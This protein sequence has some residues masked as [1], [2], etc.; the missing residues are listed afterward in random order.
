MDDPVQPSAQLAH[1][2]TPPQAPSTRPATPAAPPP[3]RGPR[4]QQPPPVPQQ[5]PPVAL[6]DRLER[7]LV[8]GTRQRDEPLVRLGPQE[9]QRGETHPRA[10]ATQ[11]YRVRRLRSPAVHLDAR[12]SRRHTCRI[13][14]ALARPVADALDAAPAPVRAF[15]RDDDAGWGDAAAAGAARRVRSPR[16][17][18]DLA[19]IPAA[20]R[21]AL[22]AELRGRRAARASP[23]P[24]RLRAPQPRAGRPQVRVRPAP[25]AR[26]AASATSRPGP[27]RLRDLVG[28]RTIR[29]SR[30]RGTA[31]PPT[32]G[33][34]WSRSVFR[35]CHASR[36]PSRSASTASA[37][38]RSRRLGQAADARAAQRLAGSI[39][40][41]DR[42]GVMF[43]HAEM[44]ADELARAD[45]LLALLAREKTVR[46]APIL[47]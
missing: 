26:R 11:Q 2:V 31:A 12:R 45:E 1:V 10:G 40:A 3:R 33:T 35:C 43:H 7:P 9:R 17:P 39:A 34:R 46:A 25:L 5:R 30:R 29:S 36:A 4:R 47:G 18:L 32:P 27:R 14:D 23:A 8:T 28:R 19:V 15:F 24:A 41:G 37:R 38:S 22:A 21:P 13:D 20:L 44:D 16:P 6:D 42:A